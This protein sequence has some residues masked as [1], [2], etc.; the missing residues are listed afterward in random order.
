[1]SVTVLGPV[2]QTALRGACDSSM[3]FSDLVKRAV[4]DNVTASELAM[5]LSPE[6]IQRYRTALAR[7]QK[8]FE[9]QDIEWQ[10][11]I[12]MNPL[13]SPARRAVS[14]DHAQ[15]KAR[16]ARERSGVIGRLRESKEV[17]R[18]LATFHEDPFSVRLAALEDKVAALEARLEDAS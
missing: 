8:T 7:L 9:A 3:V 14:R 16:T 11:R 2:Q 17:L 18:D 10:G 13:G 12:Q 4:N 6:M 5:L 1:M 15:W